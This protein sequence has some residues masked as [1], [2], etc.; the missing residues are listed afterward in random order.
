M[1]FSRALGPALVTVG[2][3]AVLVARAQ[4]PDLLKRAQDVIQQLS[5]S[6]TRVT[7]VKG[8]PITERVFFSHGM[9][10]IEREG[11]VVIENGRE[12]FLY[13]RKSN[14][15]RRSEL[16]QRAINRPNSGKGAKFF[17]DKNRG[18]RKFEGPNG[19]IQV[20]TG[21]LVAGRPTRLVIASA[22]NG[23]G[24]GRFW[25]DQDTG[26][27]LRASAPGINGREPLD[28]EFT[29]IAFGDQP[30][31]LFVPNFPG[32][33]FV[34]PRTDLVKV[35]RELNIPAFTIP[36]SGPLRLVR[37]ESKMLAGRKV[38]GETF[39]VGGKLVTLFV[40]TGPVSNEA[41]SKFVKDGACQS[42]QSGDYTLVLLGNVP[43]QELQALQGKVRA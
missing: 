30:E 2:G 15:L 8:K 16:P 4:T 19:A 33:K 9:R 43:I 38:L 6:G 7:M 36:D 11:S 41:L 20:L 1:T 24:E 37:V 18:P 3:L 28:F 22:K 27:I 35:S 42:W 14:T 32:A 34:D 23:E 5:F 31:G 29:Q 26:M 10:R 21:D 17:F 13:E 39:R 25:I 40:T 12:R